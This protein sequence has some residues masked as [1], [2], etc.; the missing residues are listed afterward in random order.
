MSREEYNAAYRCLRA[1]GT[2]ARI[3]EY[4]GRHDEL[5]E[6]WEYLQDAID[7]WEGISAEAW[8]AAEKTRKAESDPYVVRGWLHRRVSP[9]D[10]PGHVIHLK[11]N[12]ARGDE[13]AARLVKKYSAQL[14]QA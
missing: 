9:F 12:A 11:F 14:A 8:Q 5:P 4:H 1:I 10:L 6:C 3:E 13:A 2:K 7:V